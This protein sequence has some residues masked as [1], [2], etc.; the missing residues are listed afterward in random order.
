MDSVSLTIGE[1]RKRYGFIYVDKMDDGSGSY[2]GIFAVKVIT[3][4]A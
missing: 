1:M 2:F 3:P 4:S